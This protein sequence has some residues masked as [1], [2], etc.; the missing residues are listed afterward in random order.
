[1]EGLVTISISLPVY[2]LEKRVACH[3]V[4]IVP[5]KQIYDEANRYLKKNENR[6][7][8]VSFKMARNLNVRT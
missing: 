7:K 2:N 8:I 3:W 4:I 1:M 5:S 6:K